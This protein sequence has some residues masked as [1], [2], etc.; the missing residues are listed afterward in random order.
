M[1]EG[2]DV[3]RR[4][5][6]HIPSCKCPGNRFLPSSPSVGR[7]QA[8]RSEL[9]RWPSD[10]HSDCSFQRSCQMWKGGHWNPSVSQRGSSRRRTTERPLLRVVSSSFHGDMNRA[11][12]DGLKAKEKLSADIGM[13]PQGC[14]EEHTWIK[15]LWRG[16]GRVSSHELTSTV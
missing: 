16:P 4:G 2:F 10:R 5:L 14:C 6:P 15:A 8:R 13:K 12:R 1:L 9:Q 3:L 11:L 7:I